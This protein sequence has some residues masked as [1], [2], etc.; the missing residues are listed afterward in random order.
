M[1]PDGGF[2]DFIRGVGFS[3]TLQRVPFLGGAQ[4]TIVEQI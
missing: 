4:R 2:V 1:T 3:L